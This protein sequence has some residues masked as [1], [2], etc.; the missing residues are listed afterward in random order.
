MSLVSDAR[1]QAIIRSQLEAWE[2]QKFCLELK[3]EGAVAA[4][5]EEDVSAQWSEVDSL[6]KAIIAVSKRLA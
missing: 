5:P 4:N 3:I 2:E 6:A 1:K